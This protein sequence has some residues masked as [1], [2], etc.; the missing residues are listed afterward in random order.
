MRD[1]LL[2]GPSDTSGPAVVVVTGVPGSGK[3]TVGRLLAHALRA[4]FLSLDSIKERLFGVSDGRLDAF[5]L[6]LAA[7]TELGAEIAAVAGT[8]VVDIWIQPGRDTERVAHLLAD[9]SS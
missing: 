8:A 1:D 4:P 2:V 6:R 9:N 5:A 7:E 3:T